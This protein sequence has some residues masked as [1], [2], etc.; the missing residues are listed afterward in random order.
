MRWA[1]MKN[2]EYTSTGLRRI[3]RA[4]GSTMAGLADAFRREA[5]FRQELALA[6]MLVPLGLFLGGSGVER[7]V[8]VGS[9][10]ALLVVELLNTS[11]EATVDR[12]STEPHPGS[13]RAKDL[14]SAAV[15]LALLNLIVIWGLVLLT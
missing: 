2:P 12:V 4:T 3:V 7:A 9:V 14:A 6:V 8:L 5:A 1:R 15:G 11:I 13:R 10:V